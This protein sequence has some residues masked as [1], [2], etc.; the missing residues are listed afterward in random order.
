MPAGTADHTASLLYREITQIIPQA[1]RQ[2]ACGSLFSD[3]KGEKDE[4]RAAH[5]ETDPREETGRQ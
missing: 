3:R 2:L 4:R 1:G 5:M